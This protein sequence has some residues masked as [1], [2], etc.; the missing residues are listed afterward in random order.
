MQPPN[1]CTFSGSAELLDVSGNVELGASGIEQSAS[2]SGVF[3][4]I[5]AAE[6]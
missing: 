1:V 5:Q 6:V 2:S 4:E 3:E